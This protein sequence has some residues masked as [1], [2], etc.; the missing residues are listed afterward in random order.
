[1]D[2]SVGVFS[3]RPARWGAV[4]WLGING[5]A[6]AI[7]LGAGRTPWPNPAALFAA[8]AALV[9]F[10][11]LIL[12]PLLIPAAVRADAGAAGGARPGRVLAGHLLAFAALGAPFALLC[13]FLAGVSA[14]TAARSAAVGAAATACAAAAFGGGRW[15]RPRFPVLYQLAAWSVCAAAPFLYYLGREWAGADW[16]WLAAVSPFRG[17]VDPRAPTG[18]GPLWAVQAA[19]FGLAA[20]VLGGASALAPRKAAAA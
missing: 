11:L 14:G 16:G 5:A 2:Y 1:M 18:W 13:A 9:L 17:V 19:A 12:W 10:F 7:G 20:A 8:H 15:D 6:P 4:L 3:T